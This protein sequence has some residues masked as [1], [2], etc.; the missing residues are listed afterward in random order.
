MLQKSEGTFQVRWVETTYS[1]GIRR[2]REDFTGLFQVKIM[3]PRDEADTFK[4]PIG[5]YITNFT[6]GRE[7]TGPVQR[8]DGVSPAPLPHARS[9]PELNSSTLQ[10]EKP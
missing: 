5:V 4:N 7:F 3:H 6:W 9:T 2:S 10:G 1:G 8:D